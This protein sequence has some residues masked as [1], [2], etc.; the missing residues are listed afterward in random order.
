MA[1]RDA[2]ERRLAYREVQEQRSKGW[3]LVFRAGYDRLYGLRDQLP[4]FAS[5]GLTFNV[6][7]FFEGDAARLAMSGRRAWADAQTEGLDQRVK[8][9]LARARAQLSA[10]TKRYQQTTVLLADLEEQMRSVTPLAG[11]K[12]RRYRDTLWFD[13]TKVRVEH[14]FLKANVEELQSWLG[15]GS[16]SL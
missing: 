5:V 9:A 16:K 2:A 3:D 7:W 11:D 1:R 14:A 12:V 6:G 8:I 10:D 4:L 15:E 13:L